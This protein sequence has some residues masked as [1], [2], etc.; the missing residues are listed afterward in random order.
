VSDAAPLT[1]D[2]IL[3]LA[4]DAASAKA[5]SQLS[6][7]NKWNGLGRSDGALWGECQGSG[8]DPY[9]TQIDLGEP[10][11]KCSCPSRKFPCKHGLGLYL[12]LAAQPALFNRPDAPPWVIDWLHSRQQ[13]QDKKIEKVREQTP[14]QAE[15]SA[16][17][18][19]KREEKRETKVARGIEELKTWLEDL[20]R[21]GLAGVRARGTGYWDRMAARMVDAQAAT[22][23]G[24]LN[25]AGSLCFQSTAL[26]WERQLSRELAS[27]Y[28]LAVAFGRIE[29]LPLPL[30]NDVRGMIGWSQSQEE[31]LA[32]PGVRDRWQV[33]AQRTND[34]DKVRLRVTWL[35][36]IATERWALLLHF[37]VGAQGFEQPLSVGTEFDAE[38]C[39]YAGAW[40]LRALIRDQSGLSSASPG[41]PSAAA[42]D[43]ILSSYAEAL[44]LNPFLEHYP[45]MLADARPDPAG[46]FVT[47]GPDGQQLP[48]H[49]AFKHRWQLLAMSGG[50]ALALVGEWNGHAL[51]PLSVW[52]DGRWYS[53]E[54]DFGS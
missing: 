8:K 2:Q 46:T 36:G 5:G 4:P 16:A 32:A 20:A 12:L 17:Q 29:Q 25:R 43:S 39:F 3:A 49:A 42:L 22:L 54:S 35:R 9:R 7:A 6:A 10:A 27:I 18:S 47:A 33:L 23:A 11:F 19:R 28:M 44:A 13:R 38:L 14:E 41:R 26:D 21:E 24:R 53:F 1:S 34:A 48:M 31:I 50:R 52:Q 15:A 37:A 40:P 45:V 51:L 30:Q